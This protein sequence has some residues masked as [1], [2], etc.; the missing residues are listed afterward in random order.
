[1]FHLS[2]LAITEYEAWR[3]WEFHSEAGFVCAGNQ[4]YQDAQFHHDRAK[5]IRRILK[6]EEYTTK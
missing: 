4:L 3:L 1:M 2:Q 6:P 5:E